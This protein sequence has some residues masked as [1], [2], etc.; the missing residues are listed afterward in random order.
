MVVVERKGAFFDDFLRFHRGTIHIMEC[1]F[2]DMWT[3]R[4]QEEATLPDS[5]QLRVYS[6]ANRDQDVHDEDLP[7]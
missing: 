3:G 6:Q 5:V 1:V 4:V 2:A 7:G